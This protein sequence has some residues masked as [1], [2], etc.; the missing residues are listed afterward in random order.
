MASNLKLMGIK[1]QPEFYQRVKDYAASQGTSMSE[2]VRNAVE[3]ELNHTTDQESTESSSE[4]TGLTQAL[5][6]LT[7]QIEA[8]DQQIDQLH[9]LLGMKEQ[10]FERTQL[11]LEDLRQKQTRTV[12]QRLKAAFVLEGA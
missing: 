6:T 10:T 11:M 2:L 12:W 3:R 8:K 1:V 9:Q 7:Q 5:T 4:S